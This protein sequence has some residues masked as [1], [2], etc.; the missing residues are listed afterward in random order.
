MTA[1]NWSKTIFSQ[2]PHPPQ[3]HI[4]M[5]VPICPISSAAEAASATV[6]QRAVLV[7]WCRLYW[8]ELIPSGDTFGC[9]TPCRLSLPPFYSL[10]LYPL[11]YLPRQGRLCDTEQSCSHCCDCWYL[12]GLLYKCWNDFYINIPY[13]IVNTAHTKPLIAWH[14]TY[15]WGC[16]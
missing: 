12:P 13:Y 9:Q 2:T 10:C 14:M 1:T 16:N 11:M 6:R 4:S 15:I 3:P 7:Y 8:C 5:P